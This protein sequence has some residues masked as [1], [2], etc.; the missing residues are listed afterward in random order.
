MSVNALRWARRQRTGSLST[1]AVLLVLADYAD[2][3]GVCWPSTRT[4]AE[5]CE[6]DQRTVRRLLGRLR[7]GGLVAWESQPRRTTV[8]RLALRPTL[9]SEGSSPSDAD[10]PATPSEGS[11]PSERTSRTEGSRPSPEG[12]SP[13]ERRSASEGPGPSS[14]G[15]GV[16][17]LR[18]QA[19]H[20]HQRT[21]KN[22]HKESGAPRATPTPIPPDWH[23]HHGHEL[24]A[25]RRGVDLTHEA[26][27]YRAHALANDRRLADWD[28]GFDGWL[29]NARPTR[30]PSNSLLP[31]RLHPNG[32]VT[33]LPT[34]TQRVRDALALLRDEDET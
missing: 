25:H 20:N 33:R 10:Q 29:G 7:D 17:K 12:S 16:P 27:Q 5:D 18:G 3:D 19:P 15:R 26:A 8:Y 6:T 14:E 13:S 21:T 2:A 31:A 30:Q 11:R 4:L 22:P 9:V 24:N 23:P 28:A 32:A 34:T 1:K